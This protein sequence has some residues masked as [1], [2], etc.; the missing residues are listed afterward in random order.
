MG[1]TKPVGTP[2]LLIIAGVW[3]YAVLGL[4][5]ETRHTPNPPDTAGFWQ[6][7]NSATEL[8]CRKAVLI[9]VLRMQLPEEAYTDP[10]LAKAMQEG[11]ELCLMKN[12]VM[13]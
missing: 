7:A 6:Q 9:S 10:A 3:A 11:Y 5:Q 12:K 2:L 8:N 4:Y 1:R 13:I